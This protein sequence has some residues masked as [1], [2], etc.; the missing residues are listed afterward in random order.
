MYYPIFA[1]EFPWEQL[2]HFFS[3]KVTH[4]VMESLRICFGV[5]HTCQV[6]N[7]STTPQAIPSRAVRTVHH[8]LIN[9]TITTKMDK[10]LNS[11]IIRSF[12]LPALWSLQLGPLIVSDEQWGQRDLYTPT[13]QPCAGAST[14]RVKR[15]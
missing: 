4:G 1:D 6:F 15:L 12:E 7:L 5:A 2:T 11:S 10:S 14:R 3:E 9:L 13:S 8:H